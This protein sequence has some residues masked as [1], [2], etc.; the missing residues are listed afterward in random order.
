MKKKVLG[1]IV[2]RGGSV[3]LPNKNLLKIGRY[4]LL[5]HAIREAKKSKFI[6]TLICST[7]DTR[8]RSNAVK[9]G[10]SVPQLR[11]KYLASNIAST[12]DLMTYIC[13]KSD[14]HDYVVLIQ[15]TS[16]LR[17]A[18]DIDKA[19]RLCHRKKAYSVV[20]VTQSIKKASWIYYLANNNKLEKCFNNKKNENEK[21]LYTLNGAVYILRFE[22]VIKN[23]S[24]INKDTVAYTMPLE[25]SIDIDTKLD[26]EI[27]KLL[28]NKKHI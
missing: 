16:P 28:Y 15:P 6:D 22:N 23:Y 11:P 18:Q 20:S 4:T 10:C 5:E 13:K 7:D 9:N 17:I 8:I 3:R 24:F 2:A 21:N 25:R 12:K 1:V 19:L 27:A 26:L 14:Y